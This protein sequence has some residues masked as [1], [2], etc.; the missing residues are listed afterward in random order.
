[1]SGEGDSAGVPLALTWRGT[2]RDINETITT[3]CGPEELRLHIRTL[4][5]MCHVCVRAVR[6][7]RGVAMIVMISSILD[8]YGRS[9][10]T[11][12]AGWAPPCSANVAPDTPT[13]VSRPEV[14]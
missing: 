5:V 9:C 2:G 8:A 7:C 10:L 13:G 11:V 14:L 4:L 1:M 12:R 3:F 6:G